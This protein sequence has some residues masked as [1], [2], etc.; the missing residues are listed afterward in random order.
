MS[1]VDPL[2]NAYCKPHEIYCC[3]ECWPIKR[4]PTVS[5]VI[6]YLEQP[7]YPDQWM[8]EC[9]ESIWNQDSVPLEVLWVGDRPRPEFADIIPL[10]VIEKSLQTAAAVNYATQCSKGDLVYA[11]SSNDTIAPSFVSA[12]IK[13]FTENPEA[14]W[15]A[16]NGAEPCEEYMHNAIMCGAIVMRRESLFRLGGY[17]EWPGINGKTFSGLED[18]HLWMRIYRGNIPGISAD[19]HH[20]QYRIHPEGRCASQ[21]IIGSWAFEPKLKWMRETA[22]TFGEEERRRRGD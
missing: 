9:L 17:M 18:W 13:A 19:T 21:D 15:W 6:P 1:D 11:L 20:F 3:E 16:P 8:I 22:D 2:S 10:T 7:H 12:A 4:K 14:E 5:I